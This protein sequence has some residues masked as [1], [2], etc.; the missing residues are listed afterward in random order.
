MLMP[1]KALRKIDDMKNKGSGTMNRA[2]GHE[3][4][5]VVPEPA[6]ELPFYVSCTGRWGFLLPLPGPACSFSF[7]PPFFFWPVAD[8][9]KR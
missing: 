8:A 7:L 1:R 9:G 2:E 5:P 4:N 3:M 6:R